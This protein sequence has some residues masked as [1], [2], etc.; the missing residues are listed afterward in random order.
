MLLLLYIDNYTEQQMPLTDTTIEPTLLESNLEELQ[1]NYPSIR[2]VSISNKDIIYRQGSHCAYLFLIRHGIVKLSHISKQ[3]NELTTALLKQGDIIGNLHNDFA[4]QEMKET[5]Q[6]LGEVDFIRVEYS[7]FKKLMSHH[8][9]WSWHFF[10]MITTR[11]QLVEKKLRTI[12][13]QPVEMRVMATLLELA[14]TFGIRCT[15]GFALEVH[16]SQQDLADLVGASRSV[17]STIMNDFRNR[18]MLDY[19]REQICINDAAFIDLCDL[20]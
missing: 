15:H 6:A 4:N 10:E 19:T 5:A 8:A 13:T 11:K 18:G 12:I 3:G 20:E 7:D 2:E 16:L 9:E 14:E 17:V 1:E